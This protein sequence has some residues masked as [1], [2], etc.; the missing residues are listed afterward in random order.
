MDVVSLKRAFYLVRHAS[1]RRS[2]RINKF[3]Q[4]L[5]SGLKAEVSRLEALADQDM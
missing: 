2:E 4:A 5:I 3:A 1:D